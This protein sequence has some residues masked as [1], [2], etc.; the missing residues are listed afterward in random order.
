MQHTTKSAVFLS[1]LLSP[2]LA[3]A[4]DNAQPQGWYTQGDF[5]P[6]QRLELVVHNALDRERIN[7]PVIIQRN[8]LT[9]LPDVHEMALTLVDPNLPGRPQPS[10]ELFQ[11]QGGHETREE[12]NGA[13]IPYQFDDLDQ[14]GLWDELVFMSD[15]A[16]G[17]SKIFYLYIGFQNQGWQAH[18]THA[19]IGTYVRHTVPFW[20]GEE[21][22]WKLWFNTDIDVFGKRRPLLMSQRLYMDN[23]DGYGVSYVDPDFGSDIMQVNNSFGG[24]GVGVFEDSHASKRRL[25][26]AL[27]ASISRGH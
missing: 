14:D 11:R 6:V 10:N 16:P 9:A 15:F 18:R 27:H 8:Q 22:G 19:G 17:E 5:E 26:P 21:I 3:T 23:L 25:P 13:W 24:G 7:S 2:L 12:S 20:E 4:G 1:L